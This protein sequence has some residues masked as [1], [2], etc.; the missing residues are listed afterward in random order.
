MS[1]VPRTLPIGDDDHAAHARE[2][3]FPW[4][5]TCK[6]PAVWDES[7]GWRHT[8]VVSPFGSRVFEETFD[9]AVT[10][11]EWWAT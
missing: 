8:S 6:G 2:Y 10:A 7:W 5:D 11:R 3:H 4:C 1:Y 9:H